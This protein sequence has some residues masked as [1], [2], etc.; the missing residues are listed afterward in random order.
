M[1]RFWS[2]T[3][4]S[5]SKANTIS[6]HMRKIGKPGDPFWSP[7]GTSCAPDITKIG[8]PPGLEPTS[9]LSSARTRSIPAYVLFFLFSFFLFPF[10]PFLS[11]TFSFCP[12]GPFLFYNPVP[13][14]ASAFPI[15]AEGAPTQEA[16][17]AERI[18]IRNM[19]AY[20]IHRRL[21][22]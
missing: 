17:N 16:Q 2:S 22:V 9:T 13:P 4:N 19:Y 5:H 7:R 6:Y 1:S 8:G 18:R 20:G 21:R 12:E 3:L 10:F 11:F 15:G 14:T